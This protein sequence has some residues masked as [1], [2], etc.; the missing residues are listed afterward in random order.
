MSYRL[1]ILSLFVLL[2]A[3]TSWGADA[4]ELHIH[5]LSGSGEYKS[6]VSLPKW[7]A[8]LEKE[9]HSCTIA[10]GVKEDED[11]ANLKK[12][13]LLVVFCKRW[14]LDES[15]LG[16][17]KAAATTKPVIGIRTASHAFQTW[18]AFDNE[19]MG[20]TYSGHGGNGEVTVILQA[21]NKS[22]PVLEGIAEG[23]KRQGKVYD[24]PPV[25]AGKKG[26]PKGKFKEDNVVLMQVNDKR[27]KPTPATW[28]RENANGQRV[29]YTSMGFVH[30]F[31]DERFLRLLSNAVRWTTDGK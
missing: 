20:G 15:A 23:W 10:S 2:A 7:A 18:L 6:D 16:H 27:N 4:Q 13:D 22:H 31:E 14:K 1:L 3:T 28:V 26:S 30:D 12:C 25:A 5:M 24:N 8:L 21:E 17:V 29:F 11:I 9:G 19:V